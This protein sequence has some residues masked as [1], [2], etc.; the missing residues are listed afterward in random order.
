VTLVAFC[1]GKGSP[2]VSTLASV[3]GAVWPQDRQI[4]V[5]ECDPSGNDLAARFGL[6]PRLGMTSLVLAHRRP[7]AVET[8]TML[9]SHL[10]A[11][12]GGLE[13]LVGPVT[14]D[15][16]TSL[17]RELCGVVPTI[18]PSGVDILLDC[19]RIVSGAG[20]QLEILKAADHV[21]VTTRPDAAALAHAL[22]ALDRVED[23]RTERTSSVAVVGPGPFRVEEIE[24]ALQARVLGVIPF[25]PRSAA[26]ACG[27]PG[28]PS[29]FARSS[30]V[31]AA[32]RL[33]DPLGQPASTFEVRAS[34][35][36]M[37]D[38]VC[39]RDSDEQSS[40]VSQF[41]FANSKRQRA[42]PE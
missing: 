7:S 10:Q 15:A 5:A 35:E 16:S 26:M 3:V 20:G 9:E 11:L 27:L 22:W 4:V 8:R 37:K 32:R 1:S 33:V 38:E 12:P 40:E 28:K 30:L 19:G 31:A 24:L 23:L 39:R 34:V 14:P 21:V 18:F 29:R 42:D 6:S 2:G 17:D 13:V 36:L 25:D 41:E